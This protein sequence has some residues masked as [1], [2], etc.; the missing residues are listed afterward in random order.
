MI[1]VKTAGHLL[2]MTGLN[3][4]HTKFPVWFVKSNSNNKNSL[5]LYFVLNP[6]ILH[7][8]LNKRNNEG[9]ELN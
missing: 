3:E 8:L 6:L 7:I 1:C 5:G 4:F 2:K 9:F